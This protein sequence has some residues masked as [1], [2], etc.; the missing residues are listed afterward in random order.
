MSRSIKKKADLILSYIFY[1][2]RFQSIL[3]SYPQTHSSNSKRTEHDI[4]RERTE[5]DDER[6]FFSK[7]LTPLDDDLRSSY[8][9]KGCNRSRQKV[10]NADENFSMTSLFIFMQAYN[11][12]SML[13]DDKRTLNRYFSGKHSNSLCE[14]NTYTCV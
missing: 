14:T 1:G 6:K 2:F 8:D 5:R 10:C 9:L 7:P 13:A 3:K 4:N 12:Q 11:L